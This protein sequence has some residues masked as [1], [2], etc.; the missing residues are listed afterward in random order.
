M[1][2]VIFGGGGNHTDDHFILE[3]LDNDLP[4]P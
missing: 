1:D 4:N 2:M 3:F